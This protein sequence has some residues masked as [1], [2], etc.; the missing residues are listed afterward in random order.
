MMQM[1]LFSNVFLFYF[2]LPARLYTKQNKVKERAV[3]LDSVS[4]H[5]K[6]NKKYIARLEVNK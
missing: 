4:I 2:I 3:T 5:P 1:L 6:V